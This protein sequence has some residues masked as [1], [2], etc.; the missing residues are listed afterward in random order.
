VHRRITDK[1]KGLAVVL[2]VA[3]VIKEK[4]VAAPKKMTIRQLHDKAR[5]LD[6][7][8]G[9]MKKTELIHA[10]QRREGYSPCFGTANGSCPYETCCFRPDCL[11][12][13]K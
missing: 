13:K 10:I 5:Y 12:L 7:D 2:K 11:T 9:K 6:I 4:K 3:K 8:P 1:K